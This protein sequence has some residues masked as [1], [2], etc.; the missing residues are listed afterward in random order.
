LGLVGDKG[1]PFHKGPFRPAATIHVSSHG[2]SLA[3][4]GEI[5]PTDQETRH[6]S[7]FGNAVV[8]VSLKPS[9]SQR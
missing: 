8:H 5:F 1:S 4:I 6:H 2:G 3:D 7:G 9:L